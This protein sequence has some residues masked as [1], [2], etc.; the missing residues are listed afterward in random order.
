M[1]LLKGHNLHKVNSL[2]IYG[3]VK[4]HCINCG[5]KYYS[6]VADTVV[7]GNGKIPFALNEYYLHGEWFDENNVPICNEVIIKD[8]IE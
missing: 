2:Q 5:I 8:I 3:D 7:D 1:K 6:Y 4:Y